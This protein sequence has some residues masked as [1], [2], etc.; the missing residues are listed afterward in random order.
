MNRRLLIVI[1]VVAV[2][3]SLF[4]FG[5]LRGSPDRIITSNM[6]GQ[7]VPSFRLPVHTNLT[8]Q[9][10]PE[11]EYASASFGRPVI[12]NF[13]AEWCEPCRIE[14]PLLQDVWR[15]YGDELTVIG[16]QTLDRGRQAAG[17]A[18]INEFGLTFPNVVDDDSRIGRNYGLFGVP[19]TFFIAADGTLVEKYAG[20]LT[21]EVLENNI[22]RLL[23]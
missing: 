8:P 15:G 16:I 2:L 9:Y 7:S 19:E 18:F 20:I 21:P 13:W 14:A 17:R 22:R 10:G 12:I 1:A 3:G 11:F 6:I 23:N 5:L 4:L